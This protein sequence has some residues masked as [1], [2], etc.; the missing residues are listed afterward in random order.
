MNH[1]ILYI[2]N[3]ISLFIGIGIGYYLHRQNPTALDSIREDVKKQLKKEEI[4]VGIVKP[5]DGK[6]LKKRGT[7]EGQEEEAMREWLDKEFKK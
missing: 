4:K 3:I 5:I 2:T 6:T 1:L 7:V